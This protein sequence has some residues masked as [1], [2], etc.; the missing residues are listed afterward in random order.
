MFPL[1]RPSEC[2]SSIYA[3]SSWQKP[4]KLRCKCSC[5]SS[6]WE[7]EETKKWK[8]WTWTTRQNENMKCNDVIM[9][10]ELW[11]CCVFVC[12]CAVE[13]MSF[14]RP[15]SSGQCHILFVIIM[16]FRY[17]NTFGAIVC[18][19]QRHSIIHC[20]VASVI[21]SNKWKKVE[22][23]V[24]IIEMLCREKRKTTKNE[25][26]WR[27]TM[28]ARKSQRV[29]GLAKANQKW[30]PLVCVKHT[31]FFLPFFFGEEL[32]FSNVTLTV[33]F[34]VDHVG[35]DASIPARRPFSSI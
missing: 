25:S 19:R 4:V 32:I 35:H 34:C 10:G 28:D 15:T 11:A 17:W 8:I 12:L 1:L 21:A 9:A 16:F 6:E 18:E 30:S 22:K 26:Q 2:A 20:G 33:L 24:I 3:I 27:H 7:T 5:G 23:K 31:I 13:R 29:M 14:R